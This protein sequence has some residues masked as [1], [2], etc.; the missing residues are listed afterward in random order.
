MEQN[1]EL[2]SLDELMADLGGV[3][4]GTL[5][6]GA[7]GLLLEHLQAARRDLLG[8]MRREYTS[9]LRFAKES[10]ACIPGKSARA[11]T[12]KVLQGLIDSQ[13]TRDRIWSSDQARSARGFD[14]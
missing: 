7:S 3:V 6:L 13:A 9:S 2:R 5:T 4:T 1:A 8:S 12:I 11:D 14:A 10:A